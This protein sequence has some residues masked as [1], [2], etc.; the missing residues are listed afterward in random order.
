MVQYVGSYERTEENAQDKIN[1]L[2]NNL[3]SILQGTTG[4][5]ASVYLLITLNTT[6]NALPDR[7]VL[8]AHD[9]GMLPHFKRATQPRLHIAFDRVGRSGL[10][11][12]HISSPSD[13][14][15]IHSDEVL[16][17]AH[18]H[19]SVTTILTELLVQAKA[20]SQP[21]VN[22]D[23]PIYK[24]YSSNHPEPEINTRDNRPVGQRHNNRRYHVR[25]PIQP[26]P[27]HR[28]REPVEAFPTRRVRKMF[29]RVAQDLV[30]PT[31]RYNQM[32]STS[33]PSARPSHYSLI[34]DMNAVIGSKGIG[35]LVP[36]EPNSPVFL[37]PKP[38]R[39]TQS[40]NKTPEPVEIIVLNRYFE[41]VDKVGFIRD[42]VNVLLNRCPNRLSEDLYLITNSKV[43]L[44]GE[45][46]KLTFNYCRLGESPTA[47]LIVKVCNPDDRF[48]TFYLGVTECG[49]TLRIYTVNG[50]EQTFKDTRFPVHA[51]LDVADV[52]AAVEWVRELIESLVMISC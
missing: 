10:S 15:V 40:K 7:I 46:P 49:E 48:D 17:L 25:H 13:G 16:R 8:T 43:F 26:V 6:V 41:Q 38:L 39:H 5:P 1:E 42:E 52:K 18:N 45:K 3:W 50:V 27:S 34:K 29:E 36:T 23:E 28:N 44:K 47:P 19:E 31:E 33:T 20:M 37:L 22:S 2:V 12:S 51:E 4:Q 30:H 14:W 32:S 11:V 21:A 24:Q 9:I 35:V